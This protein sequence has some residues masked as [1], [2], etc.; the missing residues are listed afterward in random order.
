MA[1]ELPRFRWWYL[2]LLLPVFLYLGARWY[3]GHRIDQLIDRANT[4]G[5]SLVV[6]EYG[7]G[8]FPIHLSAEGVSFQQD[9]ANFSAHGSLSELYLGGLHLFS[10]FGSDPIELERI[11]LQGLDAELVRTGSS[12]GDSSSFALEVLEIELD[13]TFLTLADQ[14]SGKQLTL[15]DFALSLQAFHL[16]FQP[17]QLR[18]L[19]MTADSVAY[20]DEPGA[21]RITASGIGYDTGRE[22]IN[23]AQLQFRRGDST[24]VWADDLTFTG[25]NTDDIDGA[26]TLDS[27]R[28]AR[29]GG[30]ARVPGGSKTPADSTSSGTAVRIRQLS[31]PSIDLQVAGDFGRASLRGSVEAEALAYQDTFSLDH[32]QLD[33]D[34][35]TYTGSGALEVVARNLNLQQQALYFPLSPDRMGATDLSVPHFT[36]T[37]DGQT[38]S[39]N[40]LD[41]S[42][43]NGELSAAQLQFNGRRIRGTTERLAVTGVDRN[44]LL[45]TGPVQLAQAVAE[46]AE[47]AIYTS[48]GGRY[49]VSA[50]QAT[51]D[52][53]TLKGGFAVERVRVENAGFRRYGS[54]GQRDMV[55]TGIYVDQ[56]DISSPIKP[57]R[58]G[59]SKVRVA[60]L[61]MYSGELP[62]EYRY[63]N[64]AYDSRAGELTLDSLVRHNQLSPDEMF[65]QKIAKSWLAFGFDGLRLRGIR[66]DA[67]VRGK[68]IYVDSLNAKDFR[69]RVVEDLSLDLPGNAN[70]PMPIE[71]LRKIGPRI[72]LNGAR[73]SSTDIAYGIVDSLLDPKTIHFNDGTVLLQNLDTE[74]SDTDSVQV[75]MDATFE[76]GTPLHAEFRLSRD[77]VA[78]G[79]SA[80]G[81]LGT[82]DLS[83]VNP[84]MRVAADA[85][86][87]KGVIEKL[88]YHSQM[89]GDTITGDMMLLYRDLDLKVVGS[90]AWIKNLLS[91]V[92]IK[93]DNSLGEDFRQGRIYHVHT[94]DRSFFNSYWKGLVSGMKSSAM[95]DI[96][97][98]EELD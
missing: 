12:S 51:L 87:E 55:G 46:G 62:L 71:A 21:T 14:T 76:R 17:T 58:F 5:N 9:R 42:S 92:V 70:R 56:R 34:S 44:A 11:R 32:L 30:G 50:P 97:L 2:L 3:V 23:L 27:V 33:G 8:F 29:L 68:L 81:E 25:L 85:I 28:I 52:A 1:N 73:F 22:A 66:H 93:N 65:R 20:F 95:S 59:A 47:V 61:T 86:I 38:V 4:D 48:D 90:G 98:P 18:S 64:A 91:G 78:R 60:R 19:R 35:L 88:T 36:V 63:V 24:D 80:Q 16:P 15:T 45:G 13:S 79:Y 94:P 6:R 10:L 7:F 54:D 82:Y 74:V 39:G 77:A 67:L 40:E 53:I 43:Q 69:L 49:E 26:F 31:L 72:V 84:L 75:S 37:R 96:A 41:Y 83:K 89:D 57:D